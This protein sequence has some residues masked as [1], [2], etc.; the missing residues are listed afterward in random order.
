MKAGSV[1]GLTLAEEGDAVVA[2]PGSLGGGA[3]LGGTVSLDAE[4]AALLA[5]GGETAGFAVLVDGLADPVDGGVVADDLVGGV[6]GND[7]VP[8]VGGVSVDPVGVQDTDVADLAAQTL[9]GDGAVVLVELETQDTGGLR[10]TVGDT[11]VGVHT[12]TTTADAQTEDGVAL[13]GL[14]AQGAGL[15]GAGGVLDADDGVLV[16]V[17][18]SADTLG[19]LEHIGR[20]LLPQL[21]QVHEGSHVDFG[22]KV[23]KL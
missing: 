7:L 20:L 12:A 15:L 10:L 9:L 4:T 23:Q 19:E 6:N 8:G 13:L 17:L 2:A 1:L 3:D 16:A 18:P 11:L 22:N 5:G 14:V 21:V